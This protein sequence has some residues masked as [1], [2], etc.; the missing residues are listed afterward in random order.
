LDDGS[1]LQKL[2]DFRASLLAQGEILNS[3]MLAKG[4][5]PMNLPAARPIKQIFDEIRSAFPELISGFDFYG[6]PAAIRAQIAG[7][8]SRL[9]SKIQELERRPPQGRKPP[10]DIAQV[11]RNGH[12]VLGSLQRFPQFSK[13]YCED[14]GAATIDQCQSCGWPIRGIGEYAWMGT[15]ESYRPPN[16]CGTCGR[17]F[18]WTE[19]ALAAAKEYA[20]DL[21]QLTAEERTSLK[22]TFDDLASDTAR[23]PLA[24]SRFRKLLEKIGPAAGKGL[25]QIVVSV[26]TDEVKKQL[27]L[28]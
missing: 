6:Q 13:S 3:A 8:V 11:C 16:Y 7:A 15:G 18:P 5:Y 2:R 9:D 14:C 22:G 20:D 23:T 21:D 4:N 27:G 12:L 10:E 28:H 1:N 19:T 17:P 25:L 26:A 24:T